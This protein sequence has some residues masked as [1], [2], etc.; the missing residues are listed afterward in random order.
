MLTEE[1]KVRRRAGVGTA[2]HEPAH[3]QAVWMPRVYRS[4]SHRRLALKR[5]VALKR[6]SQRRVWSDA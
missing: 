5:S 1:E 6:V 3:A 4:D 2:F